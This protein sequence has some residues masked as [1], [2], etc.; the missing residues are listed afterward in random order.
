M[1][2]LSVPNFSSLIN[3]LSLNC[4]RSVLLNLIALQL[5]KEEIKGREDDEGGGGGAIILSIFVKG[6]RL[7]ERWQLFE[8]I[9]YF[10][11]ALIISCSCHL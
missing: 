11:R 9:R 7:F 4:H 2:F 10:R 3:L 1:G 8:E 5:D 6:G